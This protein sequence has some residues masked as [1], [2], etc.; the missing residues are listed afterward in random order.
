LT[1]Q[2]AEQ[3][4]TVFNQIKTDL[5]DLRAQELQFLLQI[6]TGQRNCQY[7]AG[8]LDQ[9]LRELGVYGNQEAYQNLGELIGKEITD[10]QVIY[11]KTT[12]F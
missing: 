1:R 8:Q 11:H 3:K 2:R 7:D 9:L 10:S 6:T 5:S 12:P 4:A